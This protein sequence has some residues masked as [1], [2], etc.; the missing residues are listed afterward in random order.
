MTKTRSMQLAWFILLTAG[1]GAQASEGLMCPPT[2]S[3]SQ[4]A[5]IP[6]PGWDASSRSDEAMLHNLSGVN[7]YDGPPSELVGL[8]PN[9]GKTVGNKSIAIWK[10]DKKRNS[11]QGFWIECTYTY[12]QVV[13]SR[14][15]PDSIRECSVYFDK[16]LRLKK[17]ND[18]ERMECK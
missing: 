6:P 5:T 4:K 15:V 1:L 14:R 3:V 17:D 11:G 13:L 10:L 2:V 12:T 7:F 16:N 18:F 8:T 9:D